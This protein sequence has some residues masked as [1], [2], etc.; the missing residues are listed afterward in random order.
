MKKAIKR[1]KKTMMGL[2]ETP[3]QE[4]YIIMLNIIDIWIKK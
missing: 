4:K 3:R 2:L 1:K